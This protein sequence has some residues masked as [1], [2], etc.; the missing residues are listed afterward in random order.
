MYLLGLEL[1]TDNEALGM[2]VRKRHL[3]TRDVDRYFPGLCAAV[4][5]GIKAMDAQNVRA[6]RVVYYGHRVQV[7]ASNYDVDP[8]PFVIV[9]PEI[10]APLPAKRAPKPE[11]IWAG[12]DK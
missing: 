9:R 6:N 10:G 12:D 2:L 11:P 8:A 5:A 1:E 3:D 4:L 7:W